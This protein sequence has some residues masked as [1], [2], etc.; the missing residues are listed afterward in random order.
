MTR[1]PASIQL[2]GYLLAAS[3]ILLALDLAT[4]HVRGAIYA[5]F[6]VIAFGSLLAVGIRENRARPQVPLDIDPHAQDIHDGT[7][8]ATAWP[9]PLWR[10]VLAGLLGVKPDRHDE[11]R[12]YRHHDRNH[13]HTP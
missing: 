3:L 2:N 10:R 11:P 12:A 7:P 5:T 1:R 4:G 6:A 13:D 8:V 9:L